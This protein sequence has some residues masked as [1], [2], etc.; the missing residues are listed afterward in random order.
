VNP[1]IFQPLAVRVLF[2][3]NC[4]D[5]LPDESGRLAITR[6][7]VLCTPTRTRSADAL[8]NRLAPVVEAIVCDAARPNFPESAF[9]A[10]M[11]A[12]RDFRG[13][14]LL[15]LG[16]GTPIGLG[17]AVA[18]A[19]RL[20]SIAIPTTYSGS[21]LASN[22]Y[23]GRGEHG[24]SG[25]NAE[26]L[27]KTV[28]YD[29]T[30]TLGLPPATTAA[31]GMNAMAHA[32]ESLYGADLNPVVAA[33]ATEAVRLLGKGLQRCV[34]H[35]DDLAARSDALKGAWFAAG[36]RAGRGLSHA[37][38]Q[39]IRD[40]FGLDHAQTHAVTLP[41]AVAFNAPAAGDAMDA[42]SG[43]LG[44]PDAALGLHELNRRLGLATGYRD[45][46]MPHEGIWRAAEL[47]A[48]ANVVHPRPA[49]L[50]DVRRIVEAAWAGEPPP[51]V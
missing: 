45:L 7:V 38:A 11:A 6:A 44:V 28:F 15:V 51:V 33:M 30:L 22:W 39:R 14:G 41:Y 12:I 43:A 35:P 46:G 25:S 10:V 9:D 21:E 34:H 2:G 13:N 48:A 50:G 24:R 27:P 42:V 1:S 37:M 16:G 36:F 20:P 49:A 40:A 5:R 26:A 18:A 31:S 3:P 4:L 47:V 8:A 17:K 23:V 29:P 32:V 19:T